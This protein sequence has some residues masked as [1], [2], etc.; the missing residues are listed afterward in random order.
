MV[1]LTP[2]ILNIFRADGSEVKLVP[3]GLARVSSTREHVRTVDGIAI[4]RTSFGEVEGL[5]EPQEGVFFITS[6]VVKQAARKLGR[7]DVL[8]PGDL[9]RDEAGQP[10]GCDGLNI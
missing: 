10:I 8:S 5:P 1:N 9:I 7:W 4:Y 3:E 2:H 6:L